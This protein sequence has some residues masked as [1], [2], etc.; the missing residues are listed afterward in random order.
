M[1][2]QLN[3]KQTQFFCW[4]ESDKD[5]AKANLEKIINDS[6]GMGGANSGWCHAIAPLRTFLTHPVFIRWLRKFKEEHY[7]NGILELDENFLSKM[8]GQNWRKSQDLNN[9]ITILATLCKYTDKNGNMEYDRR[10]CNYYIKEDGEPNN[11]PR[12][13]NHAGFIELLHTLFPYYGT[14]KTNEL[15]VCLED[16]LAI[17]TEN[18]DIIK[19]KLHEAE[20]ENGIIKDKIR[21]R[22]EN[23]LDAGQCI[24]VNN[25]SETHLFNIYKKDNCYFILGS[26]KDEKNKQ[27]NSIEEALKAL[28]TGQGTMY[29]FSTMEESKLYNNKNHTAQ[30]KYKYNM[31][32]E[33][34]KERKKNNIHKQVE[35]DCEVII[36]EIKACNE[37]K[38]AQVNNP[39]VNAGQGITPSKKNNENFG[40]NIKQINKNNAKSQNQQEDLETLIKNYNNL[41]K[42]NVI[43]ENKISQAT[44]KI[45]VDENSYKENI[46]QKNNIWSSIFLY[47]QNNK[48]N[49]TANELYNKFLEDHPNRKPGTGIN[50][51]V[52]KIKDNSE[53]K[54][55][56]DEYNNLH[57][58][59]EWLDANYQKAEIKRKQYKQSYDKNSWEK[60][61][62]W[63]SIKNYVSKNKN[64]PHVMSSYNKFLEQNHLRIQQQSQNMMGNVMM[65]N[66]VNNVN[67]I[68]MGNNII[69]NINQNMNIGNNM[70]NNMNMGNN[71]LKNGKIM[72]NNI[73]MN[74]QKNKNNMKN[75]QLNQFKNNIIMNNQNMMGN[76][77]MNK[78]FAN[79]NM[80]NMGGNN[81]NNMNNFGNNQMMNNN[82]MMNNNNANI[83]MNPWNFKQINPKGF[84]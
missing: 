72:N 60:E 81:I 51:N 26:D 38:G 75:Q 41:S 49:L 33:Y 29:S 73:I 28:D 13:V 46:R 30:Q 9:V 47:V 16:C 36:N 24:A 62:I 27:Y 55:K 61:N 22:I 64:N 19:F 84:I 82:I 6:Q 42:Q 70:N 77:M 20:Y 15:T 78:N 66:N 12:S 2:K 43:L 8:Y 52:D 45:E 54:E 21:N 32:E 69:G 35:I 58:T 56:I 5:V 59:N 7:K 48:N 10:E 25:D 11:R 68:N 31:I 40:K 80:G 67:Q 76:M 57:E 34:K 1:Q 4:R 50:L 79:M 18:T 39:K 37:V 14:G 17:M 63:Q 3:F 53:L 44:Q 23:Q 71:K 74:H 83:N 65:N